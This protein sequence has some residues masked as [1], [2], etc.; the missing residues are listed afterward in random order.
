MRNSVMENST[1]I[2]GYKFFITEIFITEI[3]IT[4]IFITAIFITH[5]LQIIVQFSGQPTPEH[6]NLNMQH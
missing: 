1:I 5:Y 6:I 3:F 4:A 2:R